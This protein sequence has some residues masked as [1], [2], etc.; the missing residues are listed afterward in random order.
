MT[1]SIGPGAQGGC[2][3]GAVRY[4]LKAKPIVVKCCHCRAC[5]RQTGSAF[6]INA[7]IEPEQVEITGAELVQTSHETASGHGQANLHCPQ[8]GVS[9]YGVF[10]M[11]GDGIWFLRGGTLDDTGSLEPDLHIY[12][13]SKLPWVRIPEDAVQFPGFYSGRDIPQVFGTDGAARFRAALG[14]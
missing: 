6:A 3:C 8:C 10:A 2:D 1:A 7:L 14:R 12:T 4:R 9:V 13:E 5:Q 11:A